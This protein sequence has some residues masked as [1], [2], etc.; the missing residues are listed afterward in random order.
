M[1]ILDRLIGSFSSYGLLL[2]MDKFFHKFIIV[3]Y[4]NYLVYS[5]ENIIKSKPILNVLLNWCYFDGQYAIVEDDYLNDV[6]YF[7]NNKTEK[8]LYLIISKEVTNYIKK[9]PK[10]HELEFAEVTIEEDPGIEV[11]ITKREYIDLFKASSFITGAK[12][13][14]YVEGK[15]AE[16]IFFNMYYPNYDSMSKKQREFYLYFRSE[17]KKGNFLNTDLSYVFLYIYERINKLEWTN[18]DDVLQSIFNVWLFYR[19]QYPNLDGYLIHWCFDFIA[20]NSPK[21]TIFQFAEF[22]YEKNIKPIPIINDLIINNVIRNKQNKFKLKELEILSNYKISKS[23][24]YQSTDKVLIE[25][26][27]GDIFTLTNK[28]SLKMNKKSILD[29]FSPKT[30]RGKIKA[31]S[32]AIYELDP[33]EYEISYTIFSNNEPLKAFITNMLRY[34][35]NALRYE[36]SYKSKLKNVELSDEYSKL[37]DEYFL[38]KVNKITKEVAISSININM[39]NVKTLKQESEEILTILAVKNEEDFE[40]ETVETKDD[41]ITIIKNVPNSY[42][43]FNFIKDMEIS[44]R[45]VLCAILNGSHKEINQIA[46]KYCTMSDILVDEINN[47]S[48]QNIGDILINTSISPLSINEEYELILREIFEKGEI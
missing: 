45:E 28:Y 2:T 38:R 44:Q 10:K 25:K 39:E 43:E 15:R 32:N 5:V 9:K 19:K 35:E 14:E 47:L 20:L 21:M 27:I 7:F 18:A 33:K 48:L 23:K 46:T 4:R 16:F 13:F 31:Y 30:L 6:V 34:S 12:R 22:I 8:K 1:S 29:M 40:E 26:S 36:N 17:L 37:I 24:F 3:G 11:N 42:Y 41:I